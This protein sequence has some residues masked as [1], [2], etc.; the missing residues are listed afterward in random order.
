[1]PSVLNVRFQV[2]SLRPTD[3]GHGQEKARDPR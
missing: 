2:G 1:M 3:L